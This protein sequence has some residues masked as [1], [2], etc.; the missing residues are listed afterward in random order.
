MLM[1]GY[2]AGL[3]YRIGDMDEGTFSCEVIPR[4]RYNVALWWSR[5]FLFTDSCQLTLQKASYA[6]L[7]TSLKNRSPPPH[8][9]SGTVAQDMIYYCT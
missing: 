8:S 9:I 1:H 4:A 5:S 3:V 2:N 6:W 7:S